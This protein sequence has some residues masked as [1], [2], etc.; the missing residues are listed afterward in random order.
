MKIYISPSN[1]NGNKYAFG[2]TNE[3][4][5]CNKIADKVVEDL[6]LNA[7]TV[8]KAKKG[9]AMVDSIKESNTFKADLHICIHTNAGGGA[10]TVVF[11]YD[12]SKT[13]M[14][15]AQPIY[16]NVQS[17]TPGKT[18]YGV[19]AYPELAEINSTTAVCVYIEVE[20]HDNKDL[21][22]WI[23]SNVDKIAKAIVK[24]ICEGCNK[25]YRDNSG[26]IY[27]VQVGAFTEKR[28]AENL[29]KEL[30][31]KGYKTIIKVD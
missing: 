23:I 3:M 14:Q 30:N 21:A 2:N 18:E 25:Q 10:G 1:Q 9:Q 22:K 24:G 31:N 20:F 26:H 7:F 15:Y 11:V 8:K 28:G 19:R 12:K 27:R 13:N 16:K 6:T 5:V 4:E 17:I 29:A